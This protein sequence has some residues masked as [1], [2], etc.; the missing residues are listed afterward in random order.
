MSDDLDPRVPFD[1][2]V[3]AH[4]SVE[5]CEQAR[6]QLRLAQR[7]AKIVGELAAVQERLIDNGSAIMVDMIGHQSHVWIDRLGDLINSVDAATP[8]DE[9]MAAPVF[10]G[11][12][13]L[14]PLSR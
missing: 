14:F 12:R 9:A 13:R 3:S 2:L 5:Q 11:A 10:E 1:P 6:K 8:E 4:P 7:M